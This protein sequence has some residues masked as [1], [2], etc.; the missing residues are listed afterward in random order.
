MIL[1]HGLIFYIFFCLLSNY[2]NVELK[3]KLERE[4]WVGPFI[5]EAFLICT[6]P[7]LVI[8][9]HNGIFPFS[10]FSALWLSTCRKG[11]CVC[12]MGDPGRLQEQHSCLASEGTGSEGMDP[13][14][15]AS[16]EICHS[17]SF[18]LVG[19]VGGPKALTHFP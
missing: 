10:N 12:S 3:H 5:F 7:L 19:E 17:I 11:K 15:L 8:C 9:Q 1:K 6:Y 18:S 16:S 2:T 13:L 14:G 4:V